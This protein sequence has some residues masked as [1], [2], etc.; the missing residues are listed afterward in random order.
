MR[1]KVYHKVFYSSSNFP[2]F[3]KAAL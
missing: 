1:V 2:N 3:L